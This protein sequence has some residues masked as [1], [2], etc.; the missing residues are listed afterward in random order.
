MTHPLAGDCVED[1]VWDAVDEA[2]A[3][4]EQMAEIQEQRDRDMNTIDWA[5]EAA[6]EMARNLG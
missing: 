3:S 5:E 2:W 6:D 1:M 4:S